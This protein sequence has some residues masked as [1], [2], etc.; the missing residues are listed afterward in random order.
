MF[1]EREENLIKHIAEN[2]FSVLRAVN[3]TPQSTLKLFLV[4]CFINISHQPQKNILFCHFKIFYT[5]IC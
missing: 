5:T 3:G 1:Y 4:E 2:S